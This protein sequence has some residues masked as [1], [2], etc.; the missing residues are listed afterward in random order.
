MGGAWCR[1]N[2]GNQ[3]PKWML[4]VGGLLVGA[5]VAWPYLK[6]APDV[7]RPLNVEVMDPA[8]STLVESMI[9]NIEEDPRNATLRTELGMAYEANTLW[10]EARQSYAH[11]LALERGDASG[12]YA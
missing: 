7:S 12:G 11:A 5:W 9:E 1:K 3:R 10:G 4:L 6:P 8:V 2:K